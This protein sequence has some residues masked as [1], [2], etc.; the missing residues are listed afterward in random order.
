MTIKNLHGISKKDL[1]KAETN[2]L[3]KKKKKY[4]TKYIKQ[5]AANNADFLHQQIIE[6]GENIFLK[7]NKMAIIYD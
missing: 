2:Y 3:F 7:K 1:E 4:K 6:K 5:S